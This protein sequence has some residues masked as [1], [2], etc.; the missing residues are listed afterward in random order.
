MRN[1]AL[2]RRLAPLLTAAALAAGCGALRETKTYQVEIRVPAPAARPG[3]LRARL[4]LAAVDALPEPN[5]SRTEEFVLREKS[6]LASILLAAAAPRMRSAGLEPLEPREA[7]TA[8]GR[9]VIALTRLEAQLEGNRWL[10][11]AALTAELTDRLGKVAGR[12]ESAGRG[13]YDDNRIMAGAAGLAMGQA[14]AEAMDRLPWGQLSLA[15]P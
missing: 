6:P 7:A 12:W 3:P 13:A 1:R 9:I 2:P 10:A 15:G 11:G 5:L 4:V 8:S 14:I